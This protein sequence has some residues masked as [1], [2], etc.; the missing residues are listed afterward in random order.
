MDKFMTEGPDGWINENLTLG[1]AE[2][3]IGAVHVTHESKN[4][5]PEVLTADDIAQLKDVAA[6]MKDGTLSIDLHTLP[7]ES[8]VSANYTLIG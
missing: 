6:Q 5:I 4:P 2:G 1:V 7:E 8:A 3:A